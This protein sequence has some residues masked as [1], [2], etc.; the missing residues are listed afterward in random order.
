MNLVWQTSADTRESATEALHAA[1]AEVRERRGFEPM[2][3]IVV[4]AGVVAISRA[5][6]SLFRDT[7]FRGVLIDLT[8]DPVEIREMP[9]WDRR[10]VLLIGSNGPQ[11]HEFTSDAE[12]TA[13]ISSVKGA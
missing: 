11:F 9:G 5:L 1:G 4:V 13:L 3:T 7:R 8:K 10:Q 12:L 2:T 6:A